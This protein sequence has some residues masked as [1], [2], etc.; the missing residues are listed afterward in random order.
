MRAPIRR[1]ERE[2]MK[3]RLRHEEMSIRAERCMLM[4]ATRNDDALDER[5][6]LMFRAPRVSRAV[7]CRKE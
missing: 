6:P 4:S 5:E 1:A 3:M 2:L 7:R